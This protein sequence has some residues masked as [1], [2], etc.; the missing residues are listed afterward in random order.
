METGIADLLTKLGDLYQGLLM[1]ASLG[2]ILALMIG[3]PIGIV[4]GAVPGLGPAMVIAIAV[5]LTYSLSPLTAMVLLLGIYVGGLYGGSITAILINTPEPR[6][7]LPRCWMVI[8]WPSKA[9][10]AGRCTWP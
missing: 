7:Q 3:V 10:P 9:N 4:I 2:N 1:L 5:P 6:L 8:L